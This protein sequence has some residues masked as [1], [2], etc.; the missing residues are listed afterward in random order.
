MNIAVTKLDHPVLIKK[1]QLKK[2]MK[3]IIIIPFLFFALFLNAQTGD[4]PQKIN[5]PFFEKYPK[6]RDINWVKDSSIYS[7]EFYQYGDLFTSLYDEEG[8]WIETGIVIADNELPVKIRQELIGKYPGSI[9]IYSERV[10]TMKGDN[11]FR[12]N[13]E[14]NN[15]SLIINSD[16]QGNIL[17]V[18][19]NNDL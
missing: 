19:K 7:I 16:A 9:I 8:N 5:D 18:V 10:E 11:Y 14:T 3:R 15:A 1:Y 2:Y 4:L 12:V 13:I 6:A 17:K